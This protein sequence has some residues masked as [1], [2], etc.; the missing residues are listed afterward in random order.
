[1][2]GG[3]FG[4]NGVQFFSG[5]HVENIYFPVTG[6][7][8]GTYI[9]E[10]QNFITNGNDDVWTVSIFF[11]G[12]LVVTQSGTGP[13]G[14]L[15]FDFTEGS[16]LRIGGMPECSPDSNECCYNTDCLVAGEICVQRTC[17]MEGSP[18]FTL[19]WDGDDD[20]DLTVGTPLGTTVSFMHP[21]D[22]ESGGIFGEPGSQFRPGMH[23]ENVF[24]PGVGGP[25]GTYTFAVKSFN[26][27][28]ENARWDAQVFVNGMQ[29]ASESG[30][31][32]S[33]TFT[34]IYLKESAALLEVDRDYDLLRLPGSDCSTLVDECCVDSDCGIFRDQVCFARTCVGEGRLRFTLEWSGNDGLYLSVMIPG[35]TTLSSTN[36]AGRYSGALWDSIDRPS[37][38]IRNLFFP[39]SA[40]GGSYTYIVGG[41][42]AGQEWTVR[43]HVDGAETIS[44]SGSGEAG[45]FFFEL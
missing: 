17:I 24:F 22:A 44:Y 27:V 33:E 37:V 10:V 4:E 16:T 28:G 31:G 18:R 5:M 30:F 36:T 6:G 3:V 35:W 13:S 25:F 9:Y 12:E 45:I 1:V 40:P 21:I 11:G 42:A 34:Y 23:L 26:A 8:I 41:A 29:V 7:P 20:Y 19:T 15:Q 39:E 38:H 43:I 2:S 32:D 14:E